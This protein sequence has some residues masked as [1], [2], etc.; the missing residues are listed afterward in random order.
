MCVCF[1][2]HSVRRTTS[3]TWC[4]RWSSSPRLTS[5]G[6]ERASR[7][8]SEWAG[9]TCQTTVC[10]CV[11]FIWCTTI[12]VCLCAAGGSLTQR[13][14]TP[15]TAPPPIRSVRYDLWLINL[16]NCLQTHDATSAFHSPHKPTFWSSHLGFPA[17]ELQKPFFWGQEYPRWDDRAWDAHLMLLSGAEEL[18]TN[19]Y[20]TKLRD[21]L[22]R[23]DLL[24]RRTHVCTCTR[25]CVLPGKFNQ[26]EAITWFV[27][28]ALLLPG[29]CDRLLLVAAG[30]EPGAVTSS[31][32][33]VCRSLSYGAIG[34]IVGHELTHGFDSNGK[35]WSTSGNRHSDVGD[36]LLWDSSVS[37]TGR[38]YDSNGNLDQWWSNS[39]VTA[40]TE[41]TKCMI[42]QYNDYQWEEAGL[43]VR[44]RM[45]H[46][47]SHVAASCW[48]DWTN[49]LQ[50]VSCGCF[51][52]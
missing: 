40:F 50:Q 22:M 30:Q 11:C 18:R 5:A 48:F 12:R 42:D 44:S 28:P 32:C 20:R 9:L 46:Y 37:W 13:R 35:Y 49:P 1:S 3:V 43:N 17:G 27:S 45:H 26:W 7:E 51:G 39:S 36:L 38:K 33:P 14:W 23:K 6:S 16:C 41:K 21:K 19:H 24:P 25:T 4:R 15:S 2:L 31:L 52:L 29:S 8:Q 47:T 34:V 10:V